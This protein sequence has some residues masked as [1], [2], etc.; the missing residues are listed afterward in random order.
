MTVAITAELKTKGLAL[1]MDHFALTAFTQ[2]RRP[3]AL[4]DTYVPREHCQLIKDLHLHVPQGRLN[5][6]TA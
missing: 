3:E 6:A 4:N 5:C 1:R 2:F